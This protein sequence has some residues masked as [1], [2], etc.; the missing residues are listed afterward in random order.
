MPAHASAPR[1]ISAFAVAAALSAAVALPTGAFAQERAPKGPIEITVG[2]SAGGTPDVLMRRVAKVLA[3]ERIVENPIVVVNRT[4]G[5][6]TVASNWVLNK[7]GDENTLMTLAQPMLTTPI[8][9]GQANVYDRLTPIAMFIQAD[10]VVLVQPNHP[11]NS[12]KELVEIA[13]QRPR[14]VKVAGANVGST[15][16][17]ATGLI[18]KAAGVKMNYVGFDGGGAAQAAFLGGNVDMVILNPDEALPHVKTGKGKILAILS[19]QRRTEPELKDIPTAKEQ[20]FDVLW[21]Q[22]WGLAGSPGLD[23]AIAKWWEGKI[24]QLAKT[25]AWADINKSNFLRSEVV[26]G[27]ALKPWLDDYVRQHVSILQDLG[28]AKPQPASQ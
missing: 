22:A 25:Q 17:M 11:A 13:K 23:A 7:K 2:S 18:E 4:G 15:D 3:D 14:S 19:A 28:I 5:S 27:P 8:V 16:S 26:T 24:A 10:L 20:G 21:G 6:W 1:T 12:L 9:Q